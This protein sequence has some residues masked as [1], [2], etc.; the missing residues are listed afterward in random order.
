MGIY[1]F[2]VFG[3]ELDS[4]Q[5]SKMLRIVAFILSVYVPMCF[6]IYL[7]PRAPQGPA[8]MVSLGDLLLDFEV[9]YQGVAVTALKNVS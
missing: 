2:K 5:N 4:E 1:I 6:R 7:N 8:N 9:K 3:A